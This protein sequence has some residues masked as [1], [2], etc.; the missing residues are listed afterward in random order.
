MHL[1]ARRIVEELSLEPHPEGG[2]FRQTFRSA[3]RVTTQG[4]TTRTALTSIFFLVTDEAFSTFHRLTSD[5]A[6]H[7][8]RGNPLAIELIDPDGRHEQRILGETAGAQTVIPAGTWFAAHV[9]D[10]GGYALVGC[11]VAPGFEFEDFAMASR[12][13]LTAAFPQHA[14][15][16]GRWTR[17]A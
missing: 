8:Y 4:G 3:S 10:A 2:Y 17:Q 13:E 5:E 15:L 9:L 6:W 11:D 12:A 1:E 14:V 7:Y 16:I